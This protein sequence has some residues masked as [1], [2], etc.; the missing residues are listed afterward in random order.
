MKLPP[1]SIDFRSLK[2][3][4]GLFVGGN[5]VRRPRYC[6]AGKPP[7]NRHADTNEWRE[8]ILT[9]DYIAFP[10]GCVREDGSFRGAVRLAMHIQS[11]LTQ[12]RPVA[13]KKK[14]IK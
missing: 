12:P 10:S 13:P 11:I 9:Q 2:H 6:N 1:G 3:R 5:G 4:L 14:V 8:A 7:K